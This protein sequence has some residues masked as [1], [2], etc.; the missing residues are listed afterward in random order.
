MELPMGRI[1]SGTE[2]GGYWFGTL[3]LVYQTSSDWNPLGCLIS[4]M[5]KFV[6][7]WQS[8]SDDSGGMWSEICMVVAVFRRWWWWHVELCFS[9]DTSTTL[10]IS[11]AL[12]LSLIIFF[13]NHLIAKD[14][15]NGAWDF[16]LLLYVL[17][18]LIMRILPSVLLVWFSSL[19]LLGYV[20]AL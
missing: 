3:L 16:L 10:C 7:W 15:V 6:W 1:K 11:W 9:G 4:T 13:V 18:F 17:W 2:V 5:M 12:L 8:F 14:F 20:F 19:L